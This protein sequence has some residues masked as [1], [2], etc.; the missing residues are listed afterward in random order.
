MKRYS[1]IFWV[2]CAT[3]T[4][5]LAQ[6]ESALAQNANTSRPFSLNGHI[7]GQ[8]TGLITLTFMDAA[9]G[10]WVTD[11]QH[12]AGGAFLFTGLINS[13]TPAFLK[14]QV[15]TRSVDDP[16]FL[17]IY[18]EPGPMDISMDTRDFHEGTFKGSPTQDELDAFRKLTTPLYLRAR[19]CIK[20]GQ[21][22]AADSI[23]AAI[24]QLTLSYVSAHPAS[25]ASA[26]LLF[27]PVANK[28]IST[29]SSA[30]LFYTL[31]LPVQ[32]SDK[33]KAVSMLIQEQYAAMD[34]KTAHDFTLADMDGKPVSLSS[35]KGK[36]VVLLDFWA[37]W[38]APCREFTPHLKE[39][40]H[41]YQGKGLTILTISVDENAQAWKKALQQDSIGQLRNVNA[42]ALE[43][44]MRG[45]YSVGAIPADILVGKDGAIVG[46]YLAAGAG[47]AEDLDKKLAELL[48]P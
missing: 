5:A 25:Y 27:I 28:K 31:A 43:Q 2:I 10:K 32:N 6:N 46:R 17:Q 34:G 14:G 21:D 39:L 15:K 23:L 13:P 47:N 37:S 35:Y 45:W 30:K 26:D 42:G 33:G 22:R 41:K 40:D 36:D 20:E 18:L 38:C 3:G 8:D 44:D 4:A 7:S 1:F 48:A 11:T 9:Q 19:E 12:L 24:L 29:D 16:H